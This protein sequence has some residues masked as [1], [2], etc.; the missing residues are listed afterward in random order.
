M[1]IDPQGSLEPIS[2]P[3]ERS[4]KREAEKGQRKKG[5]PKKGSPSHDPHIRE[6]GRKVDIVI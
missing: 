5:Q 2:P 6:E 3:E 4:P 1:L